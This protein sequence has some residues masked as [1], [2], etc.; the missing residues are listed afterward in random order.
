MQFEF[1][2]SLC[3]ICCSMW[4][5]RDI[6][7]EHLFNF[8]SLG[9]PVFIIRKRSVGSEFTFLYEEKVTWAFGSLLVFVL[10]Y[11]HASTSCFFFFLVRASTSCL[12][13][14]ITENMMSQVV[15]EN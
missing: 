1:T 9:F 2:F 10:H 5:L 15:K 12:V 14:V 13:C 3:D 11:T 7:L 6:V 4:L 8:F